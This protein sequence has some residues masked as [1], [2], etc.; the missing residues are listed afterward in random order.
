MN[1]G[2][3][4]LLFFTHFLPNIHFLLKAESRFLRTLGGGM[5]KYISLS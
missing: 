4:I 2:Y 1:G 5:F 3:Y